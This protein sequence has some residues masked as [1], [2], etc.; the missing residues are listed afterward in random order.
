MKEWITKHWYK[1]LIA[2]IGTWMFSYSIYWLIS[3][4]SPIGIISP[5]HIGDWFAYTGALL[6]G[7]LALGGV[8]WTI[9]DQKKTRQNDLAIRHKPI[10]MV[11]E[12]D[13][14]QFIFDKKLDVLKFVIP[15]YNYGSGEAR[16]FRFGICYEIGGQLTTED[17]IEWDKSDTVGI[18]VP[19]QSKAI[20]IP[21]SKDDTL[22][23][24]MQARNWTSSSNQVGFGV[25]FWFHIIYSDFL[26]NEIVTKT[27]FHF[28]TPNKG[29]S[30]VI[31]VRDVT[32]E[33]PFDKQ[34]K[35]L[36]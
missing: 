7:V 3:T 14:L 25:A 24:Q 9:T 19:G 17:A 36:N 4:P 23:L 27:K 8:W 34:K 1:T 5:E 28:V 20:E 22:R 18:L 16:N 6:G 21:Y 31:V 33:H 32:Y 12:N 15:Y 10:V 2:I 35:P 29:K 13:D 11:V 26:G 30:W